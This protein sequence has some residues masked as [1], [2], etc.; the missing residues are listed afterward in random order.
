[1]ILFIYAIYIY[2][3]MN[4][5]TEQKQTHRHRK[6]ICGYHRGNGVRHRLERGT[7]R[8]TMMQK[9][10]KQQGPAVCAAQ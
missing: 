3:P 10:D 2:I 1:M 7:H 4:L 8:D 6:Q 5:F 9:T